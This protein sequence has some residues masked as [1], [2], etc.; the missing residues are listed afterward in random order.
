MPRPTGTAPPDCPGSCR[1]RAGQ[2]LDAT[3]EAAVAVI[4]ARRGIGRLDSHLGPVTHTLL[5]R[6]HCPVVVVAAR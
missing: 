6:S 2:K 1:R 5:H 3:R 4:G